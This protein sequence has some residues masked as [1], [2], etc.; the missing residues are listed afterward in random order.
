MKK[1]ADKNITPT[2]KTPRFHLEL[3]SGVLGMSLLACG[4]REI[5]EYSE[6]MLSMK[7]TGGSMHIKGQG[8]R[9]TVFENK[10][11]EVGGRILE[12]SF[13]YDRN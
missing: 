10:T 12:V 5:Q 7:I 13:S 2:K 1:N 9:L 6:M 8:L 4:V 3:E 11:V